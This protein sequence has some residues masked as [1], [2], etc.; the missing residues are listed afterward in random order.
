MEKGY[1]IESL[2]NGIVACEKNIET[3]EQAIKTERETIKDYQFMIETSERKERER[4]Q[5][6]ITIKAEK[7]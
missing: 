4:L 3:F 5:N 1:S 2:K 7:E 6:T